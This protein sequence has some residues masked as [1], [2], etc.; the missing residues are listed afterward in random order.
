MFC[1]LDA[2]PVVVIL[3]R[4]R[5]SARN[6]LPIHR[7]SSAAVV[8]VQFWI[9]SHVQ[10]IWTSSMIDDPRFEVRE[11][12]PVVVINPTSRAPDVARTGS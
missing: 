1:V 6:V 9:A 3:D 10:V 12:T 5:R 2:G 8:R 7:M 4:T 11:G